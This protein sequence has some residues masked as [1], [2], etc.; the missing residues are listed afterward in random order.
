MERT[1]E[2]D[3]VEVN[4]R[5]GEDVKVDRERVLEFLRM[6]KKQDKTEQEKA[7]NAVISRLLRGIALECEREL[8]RRGK[9]SGI[10]QLKNAVKDADGK[11]RP[12]R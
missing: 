10:T 5:S 7:D 1:I 2:T 8:Q 9:T 11:R 12:W 3:D 4:D 6:K